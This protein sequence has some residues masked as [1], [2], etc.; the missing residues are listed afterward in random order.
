MKHR[1]SNSM[2]FVFI[3]VLVS[4]ALLGGCG[5][6]DSGSIGPASA[7][8]L[9][10]A[11][12]T[13]GL[14]VCAGC[15]PSTTT[16]WLTSK[17]ANLDPAGNLY[18]TG[19][20][21]LGMIGGCTMNCHDPNGDSN[22]LTASFTG[23]VPRP[24]IGCESCHGPG[25]LHADAGGS[26]PI[27]LLSNTTG[28]TL[29]S[30]P[31]SG[32]FV[33]CTRCHELLN[34]AGT[35]TNPSPVHLTTN[36]TGTRYTITDTHFALPGTYGAS[37]TN[38]S[39][40]NGYA[41]DYNSPTVCTDCHNPHGTADINRDWAQSPHGDRAITTTVN[42]WNYFNWSC[43]GTDP[44]GCGPTTTSVAPLINDRR[45]CQR[46]HTKTGFAAYA[47]AII[48]GNTELF[49]AMDTGIY[50]PGL[51]SPATFV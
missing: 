27:S 10:A 49:K 44:I 1:M 36:P 19:V 42:A 21:T 2:V 22:N 37:G 39:A 33:M 24:V 28:T 30:V 16:D 14:N 6:S 3:A 46:C 26:G 7:S 18:S 9:S 48:S 5:K 20:P 43:D 32:Q 13:A 8:V 15:H 45:Y 4:T 17:H 34:T 50:P 12:P 41:M 40:I 29:G 38:T 11:T 25:S 31:V 23:N 47:D 51:P 35:G